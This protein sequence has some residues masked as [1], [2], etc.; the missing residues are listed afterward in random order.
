VLKEKVFNGIGQNVDKNN[1]TGKAQSPY[2][3]G[4]LRHR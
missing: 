4:L 3:D 1:R 2:D